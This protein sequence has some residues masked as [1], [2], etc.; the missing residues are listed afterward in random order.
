MSD[1]IKV[2]IIL[3][4]YNAQKYVATTIES[5][6]NQTI[7]QLEIICINDG[8]KDNSLKIL[9]EYELK[10]ERIKIIDKK[11]EGVWKARMDGIK[12]AKGKYTT[13]IDS[14]D[15]VEKTF[16][17]KLFNS[18]EENKSDMAIVGFQRIEEKTKKV[19]S[20]EMKRPQDKIINM[21]KNPEG[22]I[23]IN[24]ALWN[25]LYKTKILKEI[26]ELEEPPRILE[27]MMFLTLIY[28]KIEKIS[29]VEEYLYNY[30][31]R[32][33]SAMNTLKQEEIIQIQRAMVEIKNEYIKNNCKKEKIEILSAI[34]F[35]HFGI[36]L[37]LRASGGNNCDF[38]KEYTENL[39]FLNEEFPQWKKTKYLNIIYSV[40]H[41]TGNLKVAIVKKIYIMHL[42]PAFI[43]FYKFI[44]KNLKKD[45][46][47]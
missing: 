6:L 26:K 30:I 31:V 16:I 2:S 22:V 4:V 13:F 35:L 18:I 27:D 29:F 19:L 25:K 10:D 44:T 14:D 45:I 20:K 38:K 9:K 15:N 3:P 28:L 5:L 32:E 36:S 21:K 34:A 41:N 40:S 17:E 23:S 39:K 1:D 12:E 47:W 11:N 24:T 42:F 7:K 37:M 33:G 46:K 8:S 43:S